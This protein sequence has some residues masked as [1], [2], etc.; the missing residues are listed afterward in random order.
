MPAKFGQ[1]SE[2]VDQ[3]FGRSEP[4]FGQF[5][6]HIWQLLANSRRRWAEARLPEQLFD[7]VWESAQQLRAGAARGWRSRLGDSQEYPLVPLPPRF[8]GLGGERWQESRLPRHLCEIDCVVQMP[9]HV[10][11]WERVHVADD[12]LIGPDGLRQWGLPYM[13]SSIS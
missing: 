5:L 2:H 1:L 4:T 13:S 11:L 6:A 12:S 8:V 7:N 9:R 3:T 10:M